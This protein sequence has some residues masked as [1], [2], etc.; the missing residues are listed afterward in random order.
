MLMTSQW[1]LVSCDNVNRHWSYIG[2]QK[3]DQCP[4]S[5]AT[6]FFR[7]SGTHC[8][9]EER[10]IGVRF[11]LMDY[12]GM[13]LSSESRALIFEDEIAKDTTETPNNGMVP[14]RDLPHQSR[15]CKQLSRTNFIAIV[16]TL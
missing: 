13:V 12:P 16:H 7:A 8:V 10:D 15:E 1:F 5:H 11:I 6:A 4:R 14:M 2:A 3:K 9:V